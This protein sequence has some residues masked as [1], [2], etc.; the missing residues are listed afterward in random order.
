MNLFPLKR[1]MLWLA[2]AA[3]VV[4]F[5]VIDFS[6]VPASAPSGQLYYVE[7]IYQPTNGIGDLSLKKVVQSVTQVLAADH[8][9][10]PIAVGAWN[11]DLGTASVQFIAEGYSSGSTEFDYATVNITNSSNT[12]PTAIILVDGWTSGATVSRPIGGSVNVTVRYRATD[13][14]GNLTGIRPQVWNPAGNLN[15]N[16]GAFV[17]QSGPAGEVV[18]TVTLN[19]NGNWYFWTDAQDSVIAPGAVDSGSWANGFR[20][21]V[22]E[23]TPLPTGSVSGPSTGTVGVDGIYTF[24]P[25]ANITS[26]YWDLTLPAGG[27]WTGGNN[28]PIRPWGYGSGPGTYTFKVVMTGPGGTA[29]TNIVTTTAT[30]PDATAPTVP[31]G[32]VAKNVANTS[33]VLDWAASWDAFGVTAYEVFRGTTSLGTVT[34]TSM[35]ITGLTA[36][37]AYQMK[38]RARDAVGN[39]SAQSAALPV[40][41]ASSADAIA[42][43]VPAGLAAGGVTTTSFMLSWAASTDAVGV[44]AYEVF[45]NGASIGTVSG[46]SSSVT[47][48]TPGTAYSMTVRAR[49]AIG[50]WSAQ[51][52]I[53]PVTTASEHAVASGAYMSG[54]KV[55]VIDN[56][57]VAGAGVTIEPGANVLY[58]ATTRVTLSPG[59]TAKAGSIFR[60]A[61]SVDTDSD[62]LPDAWEM[63]YFGSLAAQTGAGNADG[64]TLTN[65]Q[66]FQARLDPT[67]KADGTNMPVGSQLIVPAAAPQFHGVDTGTWVISAPFNL[68]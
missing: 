48:M 19:Q 3:P 6:I 9:S 15:N 34:T 67:F 37:T 47:G 12:P 42:P 52:A 5:S 29:S 4:A 14:E 28:N 8:G 35:P 56:V 17:A 66:E 18:W 31:V 58:L 20:L 38:V 24:T 32:L 40:T 45:R 50:N 43:T 65:L 62:G 63:Q 44:T 41:T 11:S 16:G 46:T 55:T 26:Y 10:S 51:S 23:A 21:N 36:N 68:P 25:G 60:A 57:I 53:L 64:D 27:A 22:V 33:F 7:A 30:S 39:W 1:V 49:D 59:F 54:K 2:L 13:A 61:I